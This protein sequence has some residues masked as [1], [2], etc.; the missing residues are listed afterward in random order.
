MAASTV[1]EKIAKWVGTT[2]YDDIPADVL[3][4]AKRCILDFIGVAYAGS[5]QPI[6]AIIMKYLDAIK[7]PEQST[8]IGTGI[9]A[10]CIE[11]AFANGVIG[12]C[13]DY[14]DFLIPR[15]GGGGPHITAAILPA[16]LAVAE[17]EHKTGRELIEA[18][19]LGCE[20]CY[21]IGMGIEPDHYVMG[22][23]NT[24]T[25][26]IFGAAAAAGKLWGLSSEQMTF[27]FGIAASEASGLREN[28][29]TMTKSFH[30]GQASAKGVRSA[31]LAKLGFDSAKTI[32]EGNGGFC[33]V[34]C[35][36]A[37]I[38][39]ITD[40]LG[41]PFGLSQVIIKLYPCC[42]ASH[43]AISATLDLIKQHNVKA[44]DIDSVEVK[45]DALIPQLLKY[46][47]PKTAFEGKFSMQFPLALAMSERRVTLDNFTDEKTHEPEIVTLMKKVDLAPVPELSAQIVDIKL[48][49]GLQLEKK[50]DYD[51][52]NPRNLISDEELLD[53]YRDC[54]SP[55]MPHALIR[56][57]SETLFRLEKVRD[58]NELSDRYLSGAAAHKRKGNRRA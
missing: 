23:H 11:T 52:G 45:C 38:N 32:F 42:G 58:V 31:L 8:V 55:A 3:N 29:G 40:H 12:H 34:M 44:E 16:A 33:N 47:I 30:A 37:R 9:K 54:T 39:E 15:L 43:P 48:K 7:G 24:E 25:E 50:R 2:G 22:W 21:R 46:R 49:D 36:N 6:A 18:Y 14:D 4:I 28:F 53:K 20:I 1:S 51:L 19:V 17:K 10:S 26:G 41:D 56:E 5:R 57:S 35:K 27:A 13:L